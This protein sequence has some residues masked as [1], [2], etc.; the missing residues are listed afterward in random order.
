MRGNPRR[1]AFEFAALAGISTTLVI[2]LGTMIYISRQ[3]PEGLPKLDLDAPVD[4]KRAFAELQQ[5][6][7]GDFR[8]LHPKGN[9]SNN[10]RQSK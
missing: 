7:R 5:L 8:S 2:S 4:F 1:D 10:E 3:S 9:N 6:S